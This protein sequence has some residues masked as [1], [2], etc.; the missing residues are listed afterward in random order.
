MPGLIVYHGPSKYD[1]E[2]IVAILVKPNGKSNRKTGA[3]VQQYILRADIDPLEASRTGADYSIC[4]N[5]RH[6]GTP[7]PN[8]TNGV[9]YNRTCYVQLFQGPLGVYK[10]VK[11]GYYPA[12]E[13]IEQVKEFIGGAMLRLGTYGDP[14]SLPEGLNELLIELSG[15]HT[16]YTHAHTVDDTIS[17]HA[18]RYSMV[19]VDSI[20]DA[21][22][23]HS[24]GFRTFRVIPISTYQEH[25]T[26]AL[27]KNEIMCPNTIGVRCIDCKLC[28]GTKY[29]NG[30][31]IAIVAHGPA[32]NKVQ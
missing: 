14:A 8:K 3:V 32:R 10:A 4:G 15:A 23:A 5:C 30:K 12:A 16:S 21:M 31:S 25:G 26:N 29:K 18:A 28:N 7:A 2:Q 27:L 17:D 9:A 6:K 19:S 13:T 22:R 1:G 24:K 11:Q 20:D